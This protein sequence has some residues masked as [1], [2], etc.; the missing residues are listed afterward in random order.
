MKQYMST[1]EYQR[2]KSY[3]AR[4][5]V[6]EIV[7]KQLLFAVALGY[8]FVV[9]QVANFLST[10]NRGTPFGDLLAQQSLYAVLSIFSLQVY[11]YVPLS[12]LLKKLRLGKKKKQITRSDSVAKS[13][14]KKT[15]EPE[16]DAV[17]IA[18]EV[19]DKPP[20]PRKVDFKEDIVIIGEEVEQKKK[21]CII[22]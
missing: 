3:Q 7:R 6:E 5:D 16:V 9:N 19:P 8:P 14:L 11:L 4:Q 17:C 10:Q 15:S 13:I 1:A 12:N 22:L 20:T 21:A 18:L 2:I